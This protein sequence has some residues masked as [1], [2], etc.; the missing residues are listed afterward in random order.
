MKIYTKESLIEALIKIRNSG[1]VPNARHGNHGG[2]GNTL[3]DLLGISENNL[4]IPNAA[5]WELKTQRLGTSSL[6]T[7]LHLEPSPRAIRFV[8]LTLLPQY[9]WK[10]QSAGKNTQRRK[11]AVAKPST[12]RVEVIEVSK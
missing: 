3:E 5:E 10:R 2:M 6:T 11:G 7:I 9:D 8:P 4:P 12:G 1:F